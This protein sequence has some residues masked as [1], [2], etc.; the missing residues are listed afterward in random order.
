MRFEHNERRFWKRQL[1]GI[2][3]F[4]AGSH[5][6]QAAELRLNV[7]YPIWNISTEGSPLLVSIEKELGEWR[8]LNWL[9]ETGLTFI[10]INDIVGSRNQGEFVS[11]G[12]GYGA[13]FNLIIR[14][15]VVTRDAFILFA[16]IAGGIHYSNQS[17]PA[18]G[19]HLNFTLIGG[20]LLQ[21]QGDSWLARDW[22]L[23][24]SWL[25]ISNAN[26]L[27]DNSGYDGLLIKL[28]RSFRW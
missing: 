24:L 28:S 13:F 7:A 4:C 16:D 14:E 25:H 20:F 12:Q 1:L 27:P 21:L 6:S 3:L 23:G 15:P 17:F 26:L 18:D 9:A 19:S 8:N 10:N 22:Q 11:G 2:L 5:G